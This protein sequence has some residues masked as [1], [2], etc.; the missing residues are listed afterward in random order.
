MSGL[1]YR[2]QSGLKGFEIDLKLVTRRIGNERDIFLEMSRNEGKVTL[3]SQ[4]S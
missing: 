4:K 2:C 1:G 3:I